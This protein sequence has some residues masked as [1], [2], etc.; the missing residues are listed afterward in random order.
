VGIAAMIKRKETIVW[1]LRLEEEVNM[2]KAR[3]MIIG[4]LS[5]Q[6][7]NNIL[8]LNT[9]DNKNKKEDQIIEINTR[10]NIQKDVKTPT[11]ILEPIQTQE[12]SIKTTI[13]NNE[14]R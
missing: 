10:M 6:I 11:Q 4:N 14:N 3:M 8:K 1:T 2:V 5:H 13:D 7:Y 9:Q 12:T